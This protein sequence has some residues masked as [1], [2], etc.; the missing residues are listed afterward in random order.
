[1]WKLFRKKD[2]SSVING[3]VYQAGENINISTNIVVSGGD[4]RSPLIG[5]YV[6]DQIDECRKAILHSES[7]TL[8]SNL[9]VL[10]LDQ[11]DLNDEEKEKISF[12]TFLL[13]VY[14]D[15]KESFQREERRLENTVF[16]QQVTE[17]KEC[18]AG[19]A[20]SADVFQ[21]LYDE[22]Q[23]VSLYLLFGAQNYD[24]IEEFYHCVGPE[25]Y[26]YDNLQYFAGL[27]YFNQHDFKNSARILRELANRKSIPKFE[28]YALLAEIHNDILRLS[29]G[30]ECQQELKL[31]VC[32]LNQLCNSHAELLSRNEEL[33]SLTRLEAAL[34]VDIDKFE[35]IYNSLPEVQRNLPELKYQYAVYCQKKGEYKKA[36]DIYEEID[37]KDSVGLTEAYL[38]A[39]F[40]NQEYGRIESVYQSIPEKTRRI[41][42]IRT[43]ALEHIDPEQYKNELATTLGQA[44]ENSRDFIFVLFFIKDK[45]IFDAIVVPFLNDHFD[46]LEK[47]EDIDK[48][49]LAVISINNFAIDTSLRILKAVK[50]F[51][52]LDK[53]TLNEIYQRL[54]YA[55]QQ[56]G[57]QE[58]DKKLLNPGLR[59]IEDIS[60]L[61][62]NRGIELKWFY[63]VKSAC[64]L[65]L[66]KFLSARCYS[67]K[68]FKIMPDRN[69]A[70][71]IIQLLYQ[72][73][74]HDYKIYQPYIDFLQGTREPSQLIVLALAYQKIGEIAQSRNCAYK[75]IYYLNGKADLNVLKAYLE[76]WREDLIRISPDN[77]EFNRVKRNCVVDLVSDKENIRFCLDSESELDMD[78]N[79]SL[80]MLH[81]NRAISNADLY[82]KLLGGSKGQNFKIGET[83]YQLVSIE[84]R[85]IVTDRYVLQLTL[86]N[87]DKAKPALVAITSTSSEEMI[88]K[89]KT[90]IHENGI[91]KTLDI[92]HLK[93]NELGCP[94]ETIRSGDYTQ[95]LNT[96]NALLYTKDEVLWAGE[97]TNQI[98]AASYLL[99]LSSLAVLTA[100]GQLTVLDEFIDKIIIPDSV[101]TLAD[102][103]ISFFSESNSEGQLALDSDGN[104][105]IQTGFNQQ[106]LDWWT[107]IRD[108]CRKFRTVHVSDEEKIAFNILDH[109]SAEEFIKVTRSG[110]IEADYLIVGQKCDAVYVCDDLFWRKVATSLKIENIN[111]S[112]LAYKLKNLDVAKRFIEK[113]TETNYVYPAFIAMR[114][115]QWTEKVLGNLLNSKY[116][117]EIYE[118]LI[119][120]IYSKA[121]EKVIQ[122]I[123][124]SYINEN[125]ADESEDLD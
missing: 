82:N 78:A 74:Q 69:S 17:I 89:I 10:Q 117:K 33:I 73:D 59:K 53:G 40:L 22:T 77:H 97:P 44:L 107:E 83:T 110:M 112:S 4:S 61:F 102:E 12:Y 23:S 36:V 101:P 1:M 47:M 71:R 80:G 87:Q 5:K 54:L 76:L 92:Y 14:K 58:E 25:S 24:L 114:D 27:S 51:N 2:A 60:D 125:I 32:D 21:A 45:N 113:I 34:M 26:V 90:Y 95:Y 75:A 37:W 84:D 100:T 9:D 68:L 109:V 116:K 28:F 105:N 42:S 123:I 98:A 72:E 52:A 70:A 43:A 96:V 111:S 94:I 124:S 15:D 57:E 118:P 85:Y 20:I 7:D 91:Q 39:L 67:E 30:K 115:L 16:E 108:I 48:G 86:Q 8:K 88:Q 121:R 11:S 41:R 81:L 3:N 29:N 19:Q 46:A 38:Y 6:Q 49:V 93:N 50:D 103:M 106:M 35:E 55:I 31:K 13:A 119:T 99:S 63:R 62:I 66:N 120:E 56:F 104:L 65:Q 64:C 122:S 79:N 18:K